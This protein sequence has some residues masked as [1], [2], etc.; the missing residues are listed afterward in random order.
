MKQLVNMKESKKGETNLIHIAEHQKI[1]VEGVVELDNH[2]LATITVII[3]SESP[4]K[5]I[6]K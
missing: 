3:I 2:H 6:N 1:Y 5:L 4:I